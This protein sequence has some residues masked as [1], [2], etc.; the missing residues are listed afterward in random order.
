MLYV[1]SF[2]FASLLF[3]FFLLT[4]YGAFNLIYCVVN[5]LFTAIIFFCL[6]RAIFYSLDTTILVIY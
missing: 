5:V 3:A 6:I 1:K 2:L 4:I